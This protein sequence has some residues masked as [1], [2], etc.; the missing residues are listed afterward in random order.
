MIIAS[1]HASDVLDVY[2]GSWEAF[3]ENH[4]QKQNVKCCN[5]KMPAH[6]ALCHCE[7]SLW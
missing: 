5:E 3:E 2:S 6:R 1:I 4:I 7:A